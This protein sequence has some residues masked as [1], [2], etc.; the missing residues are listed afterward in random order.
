MWVQ[1]QYIDHSLGMTITV[2]TITDEKD[3]PT[4]F[5][6]HDHNSGQPRVLL[7]ARQFQRLLAFGALWFQP[8][9]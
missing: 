7:N 3:A 4:I 2:G 6:I 5:E 8:R 1:Q 9:Y